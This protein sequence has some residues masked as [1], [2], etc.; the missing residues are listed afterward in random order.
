[1]TRTQEFWNQQAEW[2]EA[3]FGKSTERGPSGPLAHL[4]KEAKEARADADLYEASRGILLPK[5]VVKANLKLEIA[6]CLFLTFDAARRAGMTLDDLLDAAFHKLEI[7]KKRK[8]KAPNEDG[9]CEHVEG[10]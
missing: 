3:T 4:E 7:N 6:D 10:T 1:M 9:V 2:S 5:E 8:W